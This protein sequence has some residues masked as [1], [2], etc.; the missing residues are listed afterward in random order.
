MKRVSSTDI[1]VDHMGPFG[2]AAV[3]LIVSKDVSSKKKKGEDGVGTLKSGRRSTGTLPSWLKDDLPEE[4]P[5][6][7]GKEKVVR[8]GKEKV[9]KEKDKSR[10]STVYGKGVIDEEVQMEISAPIPDEDFRLAT[11]L[12]GLNPIKT[13]S[14][15]L[16]FP[17]STR[18]GPIFAGTLQS[19]FGTG[20]DGKREEKAVNSW[21]KGESSTRPLSGVRKASKVHARDSV[22]PKDS[23][24]AEEKRHGKG[25]RGDLSE[26]NG[27][28]PSQDSSPGSSNLK[29]LQRSSRIGE[30]DRSG[31]VRLAGSGLRVEGNSGDGQVSQAENISGSSWA[32]VDNI[33]TGAS[34]RDGSVD[35]VSSNS[36]HGSKMSPHGK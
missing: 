22:S 35:F 30:Q 27:S 31:A 8:D 3:G 26:I 24:P 19:R 32:N 20:N 9:N 10:R 12:L 23:S 34:L 36:H 29:K 6:K 25:M 28:A 5:V 4:K 7:E 18:S 15:P 11:S 16:L 13:R 2:R 14:G 17:A 21:S 33:S 1:Q